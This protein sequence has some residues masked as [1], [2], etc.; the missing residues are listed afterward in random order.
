MT[1]IATTWDAARGRGSWTVSGS[2]LASGNDLATAVIISLFTDRV[3][4][5]DDA[6]PDNTGDRRGWWGDEGQNIPIGS[7]LWLL[8]RS[9]LTQQVANDAVT[10][11]QESL[12]WMVSDGVA[13]STTTT[14]TIVA[15]NQLR[16]V[17]TI[18]RS[19]DSSLSLNFAWAWQDIT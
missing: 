8:A 19:N 3:A 13:S 14:A 7:R 16:L 15:D 1:D 10:Y 11:A 6:L 4:A 9:K 12:G 17:V 5:P 2:A 18:N